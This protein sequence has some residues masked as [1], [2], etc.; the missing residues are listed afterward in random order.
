MSAVACEAPPVATAP[1]DPGTAD[2]VRRLAAIFDYVAADYPGAVKDG[3]VLS[4]AE[5]AEQLSFVDDAAAL[6]HNLGAGP[7]KPDDLFARIAQVGAAVK[8]KAPPKKVAALSR[9]LGRDVLAA[10]GVVLAPASPPSF[11][12]GEVLFRDNCAQCHG[13]TGAGDGRR[14]PE[15]SPPP[16]SF[17]DPEVMAG[18][19]PARAF[20]ALTDGVAD[21]AMASFGLLSPSDRWNLAFYV[22]TLRYSPAAATHGHKV[23]RDAGAPVPAT[24]S[25]L[26]GHSDAQLTAALGQAHINPDDLADVRAY[27]RR[28]AAYAAEGAPMDRARALIGQAVAATRED[29]SAAARR[30][31]GAAYLDGFEPHEASLRAIDSDLV[32]RAEAEFL[33][34]REAI[35]GGA[36]ASDI[37]QRALM[38]GTVLDDADA[39][40]SGNGGGAVVAFSTSLAV[41]LREG[42]E[43]ALLILLLLGLARRSGAS[44]SD[45]RAIHG[46]WVAAIGAGA[47]TW[48]VAGWLIA[49]IGGVQRELIEG[50][51]SVLAAVV[52]LTVSHFVLARLDAERRVTSLKDRLARAGSSGRRRLVLA[53][54][55]FVAVYRE[56]FE[57]V[58]FLRAIMLD[59]DASGAAIALGAAVAVVLLIA[60]VFAMTK[61]GKR[62][63]PG[64]MLTGLGTILCALAVI[65][66]GK[67]V[68]ALQE[69]GTVA[70][71]PITGPRIDILGVFPTLETLLAQAAVLLAFVALTGWAL[72]RGRARAARARHEAAAA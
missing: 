5:Y 59:A 40:L 53:G 55:A 48:V 35:A 47:V 31:A 51:I 9:D 25:F 19:T 65:L 63:R 67:G 8:E 36:P 14:A 56:A 33:A 70:I 54:L 24:A 21:T 45:T 13:E 66:A 16:R 41:I 29:D 68:R 39:A 3:R 4:A 44:D 72:A 20:S 15:L 32:L 7:V 58:L 64:P 43:G 30:A 49:I 10:Y 28:V 2:K 26:A 11:A 38:L 62:L 61:L 18:M 37:E 12:R 1:Q 22:H 34:L 60:L 6:A 27:L 50:V 52:L 42:I 46:G 71:R 23:Y 17:H 57:A 69:A